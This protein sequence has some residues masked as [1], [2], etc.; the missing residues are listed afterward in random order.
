ML[1]AM[2]CSVIVIIF[3]G[4]MY[5]AVVEF[6]P[7]QRV[8][9]RNAL[10]KKL[11]KAGT[12]ESDPKYLE[13]LK[14][15]EE[16]K[17]NAANTSEY[18]HETESGCKENF[19]VFF[20]WSGQFGHLCFYIQGSSL[21]VKIT[22]TPLLEFLKSKKQKKND[23]KNDIRPRKREL[24][25]E[26]KRKEEEKRKAERERRKEEKKNSR[27]DEKNKVRGRSKEEKK[28]SK[29]SKEGEGQT[30]GDVKTHIIIPSDPA[31][32]QVVMRILKCN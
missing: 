30:V 2:Y 6:S 28:D 21:K 3:L 18:F 14:K 1:S 17:N 5:H 31:I 10:K 20:Y 19:N 15:L 11:S 23:L 22:S 8:P 12:L 4:K 13:F 27:Y 29:C 7:F 26:R 9:R 24:E 25:K 16:Y 32:L